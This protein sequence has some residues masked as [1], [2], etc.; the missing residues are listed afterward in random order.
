MWHEVDGCCTAL[1]IT[2]LDL[3]RRVSSKTGV[4][5][6]MTVPLCF[7][8]IGTRYHGELDVEL[9]H[10][11]A[12]QVNCQHSTRTCGRCPILRA[13]SGCQHSSRGCLQRSPADGAIAAPLLMAS[14]TEVAN[15]VLLPATAIHHCCWSLLPDT[16]SSYCG[17]VT[18][19]S[20]GYRS[21]L[22]DLRRAVNAPE[23]SHAR[24]ADP[25]R[26]AHIRKHHPAATPRQHVLL[27]G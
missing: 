19:T 8:S 2:L 1:Y 7:V 20:H 14:Q 10:P 13:H 3:R 9:L 27:Q 5:Q 4:D 22:E 17:T 12:A 18:A 21:L 15:F 26:H 25:A 16:A 6:L 11:A 23:C 24:A